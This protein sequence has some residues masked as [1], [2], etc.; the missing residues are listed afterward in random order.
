MTESNAS[1]I[2]RL[3]IECNHD[4]WSLMGDKAVPDSLWDTATWVCLNTGSREPFVSPGDASVHFSWVVSG[5]G[6]RNL[7]IDTTEVAYLSGRDMG[8]S[9]YWYKELPL[10]L[11]VLEIREWLTKGS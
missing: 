6:R 8:D 11:A 7:E 9:S 10:P 3:R 1:R 5:V 2:A 4:N